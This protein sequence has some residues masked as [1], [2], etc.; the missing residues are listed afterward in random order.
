MNSEDEYAVDLI[1]PCLK[2]EDDEVRK[3]ALIALYNL[4]G[5]EILDEVIMSTDYSSY[6]KNEAQELINEY[7]VQD[8]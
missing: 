7:E 5:R 1:M 3:N 6:L 8:E 4:I 2:D